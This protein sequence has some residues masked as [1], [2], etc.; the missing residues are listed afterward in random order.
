MLGKNL[1]GE[2]PAGVGT[3]T[4]LASVFLFSFIGLI[5]LIG[6]TG[7]GPRPSYS[8]IQVDKNGGLANQPAASPEGVGV[9]RQSPGLPQTG[10][11]IP[12]PA[13]L[14]DRTGQIKD[15]PLYPRSKLINSQYGPVNGYN[16]MMLRAE[17]GDPFEK[18]TGYYDQI[19][20]SNGWRI[21]NNNRGEGSF[22]WELL[23][24]AS[25]H[26]GVQV[27]Q[28]PRNKHVYVMV[29]RYIALQPASK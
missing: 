28:D 19:L 9:P 13:F 22:S 6:L 15:L 17:T 2:H 21:D 12:P 3:F 11:G 10:A 8:D 4:T 25:D 23:K 29:V 20:K 14:D 27:T 1:V 5:G 24:G 7:C 18:V 16:T 26:G